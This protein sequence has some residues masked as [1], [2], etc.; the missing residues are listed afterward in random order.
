MDALQEKIAKGIVN[1]FETGHLAG[2]YARVTVAANDPGH[3]SYGRSQATLANG[4]LY[5]LVSAYCAGA[6]ATFGPQLEPYLD[7]LQACDLTLDDDAAFKTALQNAGADPRMH[8]VQDA[9]FDN[10]YWQPANRF[11]ASIPVD[12]KAGLATPLGITTVYDSIVH[13]HFTAIK[14]MT[15][16]SFST[17]PAEADW[18]ARYISMRRAW[19]ANNSNVILRQTVYRMDELK[20]LIDEGRWSLTPPL[21]VRGITITASSFDGTPPA[22]EPAEAVR[23]S[24]HDADEITLSLRMPYQRGNAVALVQHALAADGLLPAGAID[25]V[26]GPLTATLVKRFQQ[27]HGLTADGVVGPATWSV[28][29]EVTSQ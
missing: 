14:A 21:V 9:F 15:N 11:A 7:R 27:N 18:V 8:Q 25:G 24:A 13:G 16:A 28:V 3:L 4:N 20:R 29:R 2:N 10:G 19:L 12:T 26:Y 5:V 6:G 22:G 23:A 17:P 1:I